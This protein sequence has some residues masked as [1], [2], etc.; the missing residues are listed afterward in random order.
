MMEADRE[1]QHPSSRPERTR[2]ARDGRPNRKVCLSSPPGC[3]SEARIAVQG[4]VQSDLGWVQTRYYHG[5]SSAAERVSPRAS[6]PRAGRALPLTITRKVSDPAAGPTLRLLRYDVYDRVRRQKVFGNEHNSPT[7][8]QVQRQRGS[9]I[10]VGAPSFLW[11]A[12]SLRVRRTQ[13]PDTRWISCM[14]ARP[15]GPL[16]DVSKLF[17]QKLWRRERCT[18]FWENHLYGRR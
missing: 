5:P 8:G 16:S 2:S 1:C 17:H 3:L 6:P 18:P 13:P 9:K 14:P 7:S 4:R 10:L 15:L 12:V 11:D